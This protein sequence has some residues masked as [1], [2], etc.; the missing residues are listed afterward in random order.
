MTYFS[1]FC[2]HIASLTASY[3]AWHAFL[4]NFIKIEEFPCFIS[5]V[6]HFKLASIMATTVEDGERVIISNAFHA[7]VSIFANYAV[8]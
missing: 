4:R 8:S 1:G 3:R 6:H 5:L 2:C 7:S